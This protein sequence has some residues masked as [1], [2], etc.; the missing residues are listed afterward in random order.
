MEG[1]NLER[2]PDTTV[3]MRVLAGSSLCV[4]CDVSLR[5]TQFDRKGMILCYLKRPRILVAADRCDH[6]YVDYHLGTAGSGLS[7]PELGGDGLQVT[8]K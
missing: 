7:I 8:F 2:P 1:K 3:R 6:S 5:T 4:T